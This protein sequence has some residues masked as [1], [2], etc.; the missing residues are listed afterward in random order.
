M[1]VHQSL[2]PSM[3]CARAAAWANAVLG[4]LSRA[5]PFRDK[6]TQVVK[7]KLDIRRNSFSQRVVSPW[8]ALSARL[9]KGLLTVEGTTSG[10]EGG[11]WELDAWWA[12]GDQFSSTP[13]LRSEV[14]R[15]T[16]TAALGNTLL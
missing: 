5:I 13:E 7:P 3:Q 8:N 4:Q 10:S 15:N 9:L 12:F 11:G 6:N 16:A 14:F 1:L 2:K